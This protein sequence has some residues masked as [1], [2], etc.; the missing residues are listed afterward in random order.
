MEPSTRL[1]QL[2]PEE[3]DRRGGRGV[4]TIQKSQTLLRIIHVLSLGRR[5]VQ[6]GAAPVRFLVP[7]ADAT[8]SRSSAS[9]G[10]SGTRPSSGPPFGPRFNAFPRADKVACC[11][12]GLSR[13]ALTHMQEENTRN[14]NARSLA[15]RAFP[16][17]G[18][19]P[20]RDVVSGGAGSR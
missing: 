1:S 12:A 20:F 14:T 13:T 11:A 19:F 9:R 8:R 17:S 10:A 6:R 2:V 7:G 4:Y 3:L 16:P 18:S 5:G 15:A